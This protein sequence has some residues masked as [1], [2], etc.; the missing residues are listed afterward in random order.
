MHFDSAGVLSLLTK[1]IRFREDIF[2]ETVKMIE[3][4]RLSENCLKQESYWDHESLSEDLIECQKLTIVP[5][6]TSKQWEWSPHG[7]VTRSIYGTL[8]HND[9]FSLFPGKK[10]CGVMAGEGKL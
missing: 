9:S 3:S 1:E 5:G 6:A 4:S 10:N 2:V 8:N 7:P